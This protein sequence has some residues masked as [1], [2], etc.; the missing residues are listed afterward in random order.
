MKF[1]YLKRLQNRIYFLNIH[2]IIKNE[3]KRLKGEIKLVQDSLDGVE[4]EVQKKIL[5][6]PVKINDSNS[7]Y[8]IGQIE[9]FTIKIDD[10]SS[11]KEDKFIIVPTFKEVDMQLE[12]QIKT[13]WQLAIDYLKKSL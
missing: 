8:Q 4:A 3:I 11:L 13:S 12:E 5:S 6:F 1:H 2:E 7:D 9:T 10:E